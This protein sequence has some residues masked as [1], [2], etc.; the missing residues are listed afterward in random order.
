[1]FAYDADWSDDE[2]ETVS[3]RQSVGGAAATTRDLAGTS[4][5]DVADTSGDSTT[6]LSLLYDGVEAFAGAC[7][8]V[9]GGLLL[10][11]R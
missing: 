10:L 11:F 9:G 1:M 2:V 6:A 3:L 7:R 8:Y 4:G 5:Y